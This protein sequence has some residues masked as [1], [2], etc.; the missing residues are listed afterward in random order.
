LSVTLQGIVSQQLLP[1]ADGSARCVACEVLVP[2]PGVRN[3][4]RE[5]K[6][7]QIPSAIQTGSAVGMQSMDAALA[8]LVR[9]G[10]ITKELAQLRS[11][12]PEELGRLL[13]GVTLVA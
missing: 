5:A 9:A 10:K 12:T 1:T 2:T 6:T 11:S 4:I 13:G 3:L 8:T 7:H